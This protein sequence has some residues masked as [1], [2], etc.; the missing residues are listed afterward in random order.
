MWK[1]LINTASEWY[2]IYSRM[3]PRFVEL[4]VSAL[5]KSKDILYI[6]LLFTQQ[7]LKS[8]YWPDLCIKYWLLLWTN[9][10][11]F[12][13]LGVLCWDLSVL[14]ESY[15]QSFSQLIFFPLTSYFPHDIC[16]TVHTCNILAWPRQFFPFL[17]HRGIWWQFQESPP[18]WDTS[19]TH[20]TISFVPG[21]SNVTWLFLLNS[22][23][24]IHFWRCYEMAF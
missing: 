3:L 24:G 22:L 10:C 4:F 5:L 21:L 15:D 9:P 2:S 6:T 12:Q 18:S 1:V 23:V 20:C 7:W 11:S 17:S 14:P 8:K 13:L 16:N 19:P